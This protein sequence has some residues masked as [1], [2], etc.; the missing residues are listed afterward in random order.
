MSVLCKYVKTTQLQ[1]TRRIQSSNKTFPCSQFRVLNIVL[2]QLSRSFSFYLSIYLK[3]FFNFK[4]L[5]SKIILK[6]FLFEK[7]VFVKFLFSYNLGYAQ[8]T[9]NICSL[10]PTSHRDS[11]CHPNSPHFTVKSILDS[12]A[13]KSSVF[14]QIY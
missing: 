4:G 3:L 8:V 9:Q 10:E 13:I 14:N 11:E 12:A 2:R 5:T 6:L 1:H 7:Y